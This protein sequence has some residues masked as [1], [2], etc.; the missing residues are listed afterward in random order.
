MEVKPLLIKFRYHLNGEMSRKT[1][2]LLWKIIISN[3]K[4]VHQSVQKFRYIHKS[5][6]IL[7][8]GLCT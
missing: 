7:S 2:G 8:L 6:N 1:R 5:A 4:Y 3:F